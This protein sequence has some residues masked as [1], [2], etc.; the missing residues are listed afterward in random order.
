MRAVLV[1]VCL[2]LIAT[3]AIAASDSDPG[4]SD[5]RAPRLPLDGRNGSFTRVI[6]IE[7]PAF[8]GIEPD[9]RLVY[10]SASGLRNLPAAGAE[11]GVGWSLQ[12]VSAIQ[13]VSGTPAPAAGQNKR[14]SG[15]GAPAYGAAGFAADSFVLDGT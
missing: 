2:V 11:F 5:S 7:I 6:P 1:G 10:D 8:R 15:R 3:S 9:L 12:G 4:S 14:P 13:R